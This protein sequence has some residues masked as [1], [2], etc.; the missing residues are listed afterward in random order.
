MLRIRD[1][2]IRKLFKTNFSAFELVAA[3]EL[4]KAASEKGIAQVYY[5]D[6]AQAIGCNIATF[7]NVIKKLEELEIIETDKDLNYKKEITVGII[8]NNFAEGE[9]QKD[10]V[11]LNNTFFCSSIYKNLS[12]G[13]IRIMLYLMFKVAKGGY[14]QDKES[15]YHLKNKNYYTDSYK[16]IAAQLNITKR[17]AKKYLK[18]LLTKKLISIGEQK[19]KSGSK[20]YDVITVA[21]KMLNIFTITVT[22]K[23][24]QTDKQITELQPHF[25]HC[26]K[27][28]CRRNNTSIP[29]VLNLNNTAALIEQYRYIAKRKS[30]D[31]YKLVQSAIKDLADNVLS[32]KTV[33]SIVKALLEREGL[34]VYY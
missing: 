10:Y 22:E 11:K 7:Y 8:N 15:S 3:L 21:H 33:H 28:F 1:N 2:L 29:D 19:V 5:K 23:G 6:M 4:I 18:G 13:E 27:N 17:M 31:I 25:A 20:K 14:N 26:V 12:A 24:I 34:I 32:S 9:K 16:S 30:K